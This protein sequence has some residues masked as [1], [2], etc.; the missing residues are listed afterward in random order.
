MANSTTVY[1]GQDGRQWID[2]TLNKTLA[3]AD[4]GL[5]QNVIAT[6]VTI[7][8]PASALELNY[9]IRVG[10]VAPTGA[11]PGAV[12]NASMTVNVTPNGSD[13]LSGNAFTA[14]TSKGAV[15]TNGN[16]GD[17]IEISGSGTTSNTAAWLFQHVVGVWTRQA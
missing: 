13:G 2:V 14:A 17:E 10:G 7:T 5:V 8:L 9:I 16:V 15:S 12:S 11:T 4:S 6:N 1:Q 3:A